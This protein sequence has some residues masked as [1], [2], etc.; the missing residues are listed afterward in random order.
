MFRIKNK[1]NNLENKSFETFLFFVIKF[2][3]KKSIIICSIQEFKKIIFDF[4][5]NF[6]RVFTKFLFFI[7]LFICPFRWLTFGLMQNELIPLWK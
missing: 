1:Q 7:N 3:K 5:K 4:C 6:L 2:V